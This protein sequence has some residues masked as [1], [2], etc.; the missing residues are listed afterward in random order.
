MEIMTHVHF[1]DVIPPPNTYPFD[2]KDLTN[3]A[4]WEGQTLVLTGVISAKGLRGRGQAILTLSE[5]GKVM[6]KVVHVLYSDGIRFDD[7]E[8]FDKISERVKLVGFHVGEGINEVKE[9]WG[10]PDKVVETG[11]QTVLYYKEVEITLIDGKVVDGKFHTAQ[12]EPGV[13]P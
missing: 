7:R 11:N 5:D 3:G 12:P 13:K 9:D 10:T 8:V 2:G 6:T 1:Q 4:H